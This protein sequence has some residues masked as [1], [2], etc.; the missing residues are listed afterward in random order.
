VTTFR[1]SKWGGGPHWTFPAVKLG[2]DLHGTWYVVPEGSHYSRPGNAFDAPCASLLLVPDAGWVASFNEAGRHKVD[3]YV[4]ISTTAVITEDSVEAVDLDLDVVRRADGRV[5][6]DDEDEF[7]VHQVSY[8][9]PAE[10]IAQALESCQAV[11]DLVRT[12]TSPFDGATLD[13][14]WART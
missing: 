9:Y 5:Y 7:A 3:V 10:V 1:F 11:L 2:E 13:A 12:R 4:D 6:V 8:G 14:W